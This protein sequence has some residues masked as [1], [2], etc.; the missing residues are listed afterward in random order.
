M[1][2]NHDANAY[3]QTWTMLENERF[4]GAYYYSQEICRNI[5]P[6]VKTDRNW[7]TVNVT[8]L[9]FDHSIVFIHNNVRTEIYEWL[10]DFDDL[11]LVC[12]V[13]ETVDKVK[14]LGTAIYLPLSVDVAEVELY[15]VDEKTKDTAFAGRP[16]KRK[17]SETLPDDIDYLEGMP[18]SQLLS[19]MAKYR[20]VYAVGR[21]AI[22]ARILN[23]KIKKYD[24]RYPKTS[25]WK[26]LD[27]KDAS[28]ML[29]KMLDEIDER[30][31]D[32]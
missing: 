6:N 32:E 13:P 2:I 18:R 15:R 12:G 20:Y 31:G 17:Y 26:V 14:H 27:N 7:I 10:K 29:Q 16:Q 5:I 11:V 23:C 28:K 9:A 24:P 1:I 21:T 30:K 3:V 25:R 8:G 4:N 22:E 19:E